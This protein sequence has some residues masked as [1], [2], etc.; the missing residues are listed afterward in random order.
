MLAGSTELS[1]GVREFTGAC[2]LVGVAGTIT[3]VAAVELGLATYDRDLVHHFE[4]SKDCATLIS[5]SASSRKSRRAGGRLDRA[6]A[7]GGS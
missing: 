2:R 5:T 3:T 6:C 4:L 7:D 1:F